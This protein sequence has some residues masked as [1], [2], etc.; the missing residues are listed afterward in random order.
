MKT[1]IITLLDS[2][3]STSLAADC[4]IQANKHGIFPRIWPAVN[5]ITKGP[6]KMKEYNIKPF[7][8]QK[9]NVPGVIGCFLSHYELWTE[10]VELK[11]PILI[12]EHDGYFLETLPIDINENYT[13]V[14]HLD[15]HIPTLSSYNHDIENSKN[16]PLKYF[17]P[18]KTGVDAAGE[19]VVGAYGYCIKP[20]AAKKLI[21]FSTTV[22]SLPTDVIIGRDL[23]D[24][25]CTSKSFIRLHPHYDQQ[26]IHT[27]SST[28][29][30]G[31]FLSKN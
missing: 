20:N 2:E 7:M 15:P 27:D 29:N 26:K 24:I 28:A 30:L 11:E 31:K 3:L 6:E 5:G 19:F 17:D 14:L 9:M 10:C 12:L 18:L 4:I 16:T 1:F 21:E 8:L 25:K 23:V 22:G 13:D